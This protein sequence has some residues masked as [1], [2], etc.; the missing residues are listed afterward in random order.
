MNV[1][2]YFQKFNGIL[3]T[4]DADTFQI[5]QRFI[6]ISFTSNADFNIGWINVSRQQATPTIDVKRIIA[7]SISIQ[8]STFLFAGNISFFMDRLNRKS[9]LFDF[10]E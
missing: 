5:F 8:W 6:C 2:L 1:V 3:F 4:S 7:V 10:Y 9:K